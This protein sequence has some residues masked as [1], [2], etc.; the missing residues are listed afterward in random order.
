MTFVT[1][2]L[3]AAL[4][5]PCCI[6]WASEAQP[7]EMSGVTFELRRAEGKPVEGLTEATVAGTKDKVYLHQE[8]ALTNQDIARAQATTD[9][10][11][12]PAVEITL[13]EGGRKKL[14]KLTEDHQGK[15]LAIL[16]AG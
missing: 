14:A 10:G 6:A 15:P 2:A 1:K 9:A 5:F 11:D 7:A 3:A 8:A 16:V 12:K 13:T 4:V